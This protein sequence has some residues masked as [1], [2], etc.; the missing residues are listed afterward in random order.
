MLK[1]LRAVSK[2]GTP[3]VFEKLEIQA[4]DNFEEDDICFILRFFSEMIHLLFHC[5]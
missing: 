1:T 3:A 4:D 5:R 2:E